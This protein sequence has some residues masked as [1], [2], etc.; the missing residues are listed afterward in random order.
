[1]S[2]EARFLSSGCHF[3]IDFMKFRNFAFASPSRAETESSSA[4]CGIAIPPAPFQRP[5]NQIDLGL[6][7]SMLRN[8]VEVSLLTLLIKNFPRYPASVDVFE[9]R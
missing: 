2:S 1:M 6:V 7:A 9:R 5:K 8:E 4:S 3:S